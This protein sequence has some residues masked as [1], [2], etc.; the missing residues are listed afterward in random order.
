MIDPLFLSRV[1]FAYTASFHIVF[2]TITIGLSLWL[3]ALQG[4]FLATGKALYERLFAFWLKTFE[5]LFYGAGIVVF[6]LVLIYTGVVFWV[7]RGKV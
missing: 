6:P 2:P 7:L 4:L 3:A 1:Q 5:F